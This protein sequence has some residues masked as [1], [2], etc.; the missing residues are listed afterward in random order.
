MDIMILI[1]EVLI[2]VGLLVGCVIVILSMWKRNQSYKKTLNELHVELL[3]TY[4]EILELSSEISK[5]NGAGS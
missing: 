4:K 1:P 3:T 2:L 5:Y